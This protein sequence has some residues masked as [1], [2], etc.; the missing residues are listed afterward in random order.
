MKNIFVITHTQSCHHLEGKVGGWYDTSLTADGLRD[1]AATG[2]RLA[3]IV[4]DRKVEVFSSDLLRA[5]QTAGAIAEHFGGTV[6]VSPDLREIS[7]GEAE[8]KPQAW[9]DERYIPAPDDNRMDH[10]VG[11]VGAETRRQAA[12]RIYRAVDKIVARPE[13]TQII[14]THGFTLTLVICAWM[15]LPMDAIG[16]ASFPAG[17]GSITHL[18]Q[19]DFWR[20][21]AIRSLADR[22]HLHRVPS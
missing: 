8:G 3:K 18:E 19:D 22:S 15:K 17:S 13:E 1:A 9:L 14:V 10:Q 12:E 4:G 7:Y 2:D 21:R 16:F 6:I 5:S 20:N 11:I